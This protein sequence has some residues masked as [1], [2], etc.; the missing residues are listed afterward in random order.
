MKEG[1][2]GGGREGVLLNYGIQIKIVCTCTVSLLASHSVVPIPSSLP[3]YS[4]P[5]ELQNPGHRRDALRLLCILLPQ[6]NRDTL[7]ELLQFLSRV[8]L[9]SYEMILIDGTQVR[10]QW[11]PHAAP[12]LRG[13]W[14]LWGKHCFHNCLLCVPPPVWAFLHP[15]VQT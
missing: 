7:K 14:L 6:P 5:P 10:L 11:C 8:S 13:V 3:S 9:F 12:P 2:G 15:F 1:E 4:S